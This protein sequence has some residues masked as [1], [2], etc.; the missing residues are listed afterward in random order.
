[1]E[2]TQSISNL[3]GVGEST[4]EKLAKLGIYQ[5]LDLLRLLPNRYLD[6]SQKVKINKIVDEKNVEFL[7]MAAEENI[8]IDTLADWRQAVKK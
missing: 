8:D 6:Y 3:K 5:I 4:K 2:L 1:M 7:V